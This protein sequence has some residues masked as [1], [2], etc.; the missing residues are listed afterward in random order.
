[1]ITTEKVGDSAPSIDF[2]GGR[3]AHLNYGYE[4]RN[5]VEHQGFIYATDI[6]SL[7][8]K[9]IILT[10][11]TVYDNSLIYVS[12]FAN[13]EVENCEFTYNICSKILYIPKSDL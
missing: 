3:V 4:Y 12:R 7:S 11:N 13:I 10:Y 5:D 1:M 9:D 8:L 2:N 6:D